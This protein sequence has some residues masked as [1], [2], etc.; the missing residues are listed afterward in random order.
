MRLKALYLVF[1]AR[2]WPNAPG[3]AY[4]NPVKHPMLVL[5]TLNRP[6]GE[7]THWMAE[8]WRAEQ[9]KSGKSKATINRDMAALKAALSK[10]VEW[11]LID[12]HPLAKLKPIKGDRL[13]KVRY[14]SKDEEARLRER[15]THN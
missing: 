11:E 12:S 4:W 2:L 7:L 3:L 5:E 8:K 9:L 10:A 14:L 1:I 15:A 13:T 6:L